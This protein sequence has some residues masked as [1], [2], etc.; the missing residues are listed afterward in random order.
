MKKL[1]LFIALLPFA[2][3]LADKKQAEPLLPE[4]FRSL[5]IEE[6][7]RFLFC[8]NTGGS[9]FYW[10]DTRSGDLWQLDAATITWKFLGSPRGSNDGSKGTYQLLSDKKG[11]AYMLN[12]STGEGWWT[13]GA[14][15]KSI[16]AP[17]IR[18]KKPEDLVPKSDD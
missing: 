15:W 2:A 13:G 16:G 10:L 12:T 11:G 3:A 17:S 9:G 8:E 14:D 5:P 7:K 1:Y 4:T 6:E 18:I